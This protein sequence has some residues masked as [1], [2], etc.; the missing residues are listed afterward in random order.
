MLNVLPFARPLIAVQG[1]LGHSKINKTLSYFV[2]HL[3]KYKHMKVTHQHRRLYASAP[4]RL[5]LRRRDRKRGHACTF[6]C[7]NLFPPR[8]RSFEA[9]RQM[10]SPRGLRFTTRRDTYGPLC[11]VSATFAGMQKLGEGNVNLGGDFRV[12]DGGHI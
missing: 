2:S 7:V 6:G 1:T 5:Q 10:T 12:R 8:G 3:Y 11:N 4:N 9:I